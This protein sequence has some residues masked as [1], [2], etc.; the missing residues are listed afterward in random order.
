MEISIVFNSL[1]IPRR[2]VCI[3]SV[4]VP[5]WTGGRESLEDSVLELR[6]TGGVFVL[7]LHVDSSL[8]V[9]SD[10]S[11]LVGENDLKLQ[12]PR[13]QRCP[14]HVDEEKEVPENKL[15]A[16][17]RESLNLEQF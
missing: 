5:P 3:P 2:S 17:N 1:F 6:N 13:W 9:F 4:T 16:I 8:Y 12:P 10:Y 11:A 7:H 14:C 15:L